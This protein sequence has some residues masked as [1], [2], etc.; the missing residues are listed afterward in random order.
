[1]A[2]NV[3]PFICL[4]YN[5]HFTRVI[6]AAQ[7]SKFYNFKRACIRILLEDLICTLSADVVSSFVTKHISIF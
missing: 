6:I 7:S 4:D 2:S 5:I 1:M 3:F